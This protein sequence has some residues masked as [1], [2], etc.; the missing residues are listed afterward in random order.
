[1]MR[2]PLRILLAASVALLLSLGASALAYEQPEGPSTVAPKSLAKAKRHM[3]VA[4]NR[5]AAE[6]GLARQRIGRQK[7]AD[8][9]CRQSTQDELAADREE[10]GFREVDLDRA[11]LAVAAKENRAQLDLGLEVLQRG[12]ARRTK[13]GA[14][15]GRPGLLRVGNLAALG[16][17]PDGPER[18]EAL[19]VLREGLE[20]RF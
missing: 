12:F 13:A 9:G 3:V 18:E 8:I 6:A 7:S 4:A 20:P 1:M 19:G 10:A 15:L 11:A 17:D 2:I 5:F 16:F 14:Q